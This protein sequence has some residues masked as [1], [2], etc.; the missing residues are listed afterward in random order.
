MGAPWSSAESG[1]RTS[2]SCGGQTRKTNRRRT[3]TT[4]KRLLRPVANV[5]ILP[6]TLEAV[7]GTVGRAGKVY[8]SLKPLSIARVA[9]E[10]TIATGARG[11]AFEIAAVKMAQD[12]AAVMVASIGRKFALVLLQLLPRR[13]TLML[14][15]LL[16]AEERERNITAAV[17]DWWGLPDYLTVR[18]KGSE[19]LGRRS[20]SS[21]VAVMSA[22]HHF[23]RRASM[24]WAWFS[25]EE[26]IL[27]GIG[28]GRG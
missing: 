3:I 24:R 5:S 17:F 27:V 7:P 13:P 8:G 15:F 2:G 19:W 16:A 1:A 11:P 28:G 10:V 4:T 23:A 22:V 9:V 6:P 26:H 12:L 18:G 25:R 14:L 20:T 21:A